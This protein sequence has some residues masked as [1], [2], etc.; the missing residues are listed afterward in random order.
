MHFLRISQQIYSPIFLE[1]SSH[2]IT[3]HLCFIAEGMRR[4]NTLRLITGV[5][6]GHRVFW[7]GYNVKLLNY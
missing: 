4:E 7:E 5:A 3:E 1:I 2:Y 6:Y